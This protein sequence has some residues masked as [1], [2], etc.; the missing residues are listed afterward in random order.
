M[1]NDIENI[2]SVAANALSESHGLLVFW[3][4]EGRSPVKI[5]V[6]NLRNQTLLLLRA[7][8]AQI[9]KPDREVTHR[10]GCENQPV[11][12][13]ISVLLTLFQACVETAPA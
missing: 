8:I 2:F 13:A 7:I 12:P 5:A 1:Y 3:P 11:N 10:F 6:R 9:T 4:A